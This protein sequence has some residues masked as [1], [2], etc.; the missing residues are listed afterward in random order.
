[1]GI[2]YREK[3]KRLKEAKMNKRSNPGRFEKQKYIKNNFTTREEY[4]VY[5][6]DYR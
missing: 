3:I 1:M 2:T 6:K 4:S 5:L